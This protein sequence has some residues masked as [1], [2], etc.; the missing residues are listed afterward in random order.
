MPKRDGLGGQA[1][2]PPEGPPKLREESV[3]E[4]SA[5]G[6]A[7]SP[8]GER[9]ILEMEATEGVKFDA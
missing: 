9:D 4:K 6:S 2:D 7:M 8:P 3:K 5:S 1:R